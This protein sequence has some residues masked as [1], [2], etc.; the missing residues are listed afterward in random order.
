M[1]H[2]SEKQFLFFKLSLSR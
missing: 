1:F 2:P